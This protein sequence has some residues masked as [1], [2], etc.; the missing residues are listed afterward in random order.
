M[1]AEKELQEQDTEPIVWLAETG[2]CAA[3][4]MS[5]FENVSKAEAHEF[6][7]QN[8][9]AIV[10][11]MNAA[12]FEAI[13]DLAPSHWIGVDEDDSD[14]DDEDYEENDDAG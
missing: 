9:S 8:E 13:R 3:D 5:E 7:R 14:D 2:W 4:V 11:A 6:L 12:G 1:S 10:D